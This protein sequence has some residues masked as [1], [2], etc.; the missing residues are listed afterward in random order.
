M[1]KAV[2]FLLLINVS[3]L[4]WSATVSTPIK[5]KIPLTEPDISQ[6]V[7]LPDLPSDLY[8]GGSSNIAS[9]CYSLGPFNSQKAAQLVGGRIRDYGLAFSIRSIRSMETLR[10][11]VY[12][13]PLNSE[14]EAQNVAEDLLKHHVKN[15]SVITEGP[16][17]NAISIGFYSNIDR[18]KRETEQVRYLGYDAQHSEEKTPLEVYWIDFDEP[19]G[20]N[21]P[22]ITWSRSVDP[23]SA[24]Q[25]IP[26][27]CPQLY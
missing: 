17:K 14:L 5:K 13:P 15:I 16:Y 19:F 7:L 18:A 26:R 24:V 8:R 6:L 9:S 20:S 12:V 2:L 1:L 11:L 3:L 22:V 4:V 27:A 25:R 10:Y 23:T 21:T